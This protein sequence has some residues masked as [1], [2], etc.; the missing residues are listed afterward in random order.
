MQSP[1]LLSLSLSFPPCN[2]RLFDASARRVSHLFVALFTCQRLHLG[3]A[4]FNFERGSVH[5]TCACDNEAT[6]LQFCHVAC[7]RERE[8]THKYPYPPHW[9]CGIIAAN[10]YP[11]IGSNMFFCSA[12][13]KY[14]VA[15]LS[16]ATRLKDTLYSRVEA[17]TLHYIIRSLSGEPFSAC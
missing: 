7:G 3:H 11:H 9:A 5:A 2:Q 1:S 16:S 14:H 17:S 8:Y 10:I 12:E 4:H 6:M 13:G 15:T